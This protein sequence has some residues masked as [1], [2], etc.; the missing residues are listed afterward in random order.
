[1]GKLNGRFYFTLTDSKNLIGEFS[2]QDCK[3]N[4]TE[5]AVLK[6]REP[7]DNKFIGDYISTWFE[8][9]ESKGVL[10]ELKILKKYDNIFSLEWRVKRLPVF[11]GEGIL[12]DGILIGNYR[13]SPK[14]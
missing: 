9:D 8:E 6:R 7:N 1:M 11:W 10:A 12:C 2:N 14:P 5:G 3:K 4:Y 13:N